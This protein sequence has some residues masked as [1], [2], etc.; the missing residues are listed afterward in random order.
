VNREVLEVRAVADGDELEREPTELAEMRPDAPSGVHLPELDAERFPIEREHRRHVVDTVGDRRHLRSR[1]PPSDLRKQIV[2][3]V[4]PL[5][6]KQERRFRMPQR[7]RHI[8][9]AKVEREPSQ[10]HVQLRLAPARRQRVRGRRPRRDEPDA[11]LE[12]RQ[13][14]LPIAAALG[15]GPE[16]A[17]GDHEHHPRVVRRGFPERCHQRPQL[18]QERGGPLRRLPVEVGAIPQTRGEAD[19]RLDIRAIDGEYLTELGDRG[20]EVP[21]HRIGRGAIVER[22]ERVAPVR[23]AAPVRAGRARAG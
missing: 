1:G 9:L 5:R 3:H 2:P 6:P 8:R 13:R 20:L 17:G 11:A 10:Q 15:R 4:S 21:V 23:E 19:L 12:H 22:V 14:L 18:G 16:Q 7:A